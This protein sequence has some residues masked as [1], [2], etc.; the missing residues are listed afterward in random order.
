VA[1]LAKQVGP[2]FLTRK[3]QF[4]DQIDALTFGVAAGTAYAAFETVVS[5]SPVFATGQ[6][7]TSEG[8]LT[9]IIVIVNL[10]LVKSL[11]YGTATGIAIATYSGRGEEVDGF[12][13]AYYRS[14]ALAIGANALYWLGV[15]LLAYVTFGQALSLVWGLVI[16]GA[17]ILKLR[18]MMQSALLE[19]A[20]EDAV[21]NR[22]HS[23]ATTE[24]GYC[25]NCEVSLLPDSLF[26][27]AC[28]MSLRATSHAARH[29]IVEPV[30][31]GGAA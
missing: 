6:L 8:L 13:P 2:I 21:N 30:T 16:L 20:V 4:N 17:L 31:S 24:T 27:I 29:H 1:E 9:W 3:P 10:M 18:V 7:Q 22:R 23:A 14:L 11:I 19:A 15:R 12:T 28:G 25:P 26:C 5:Y